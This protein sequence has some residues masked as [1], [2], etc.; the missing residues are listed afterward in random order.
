LVGFR[1][2][3]AIPAIVIAIGLLVAGAVAAIAAWLA[4][5]FTARVPV[6][7]YNFLGYVTAYLLRLNAYIAL[8]TDTWP[9][10]ASA[11]PYPVAIRF[12]GPERLNRAA[13]IF[14]VVL[15][16]PAYVVSGVASGGLTVLLPVFWLIIL[17]AGRSPEPIFDATTASV[18]YQTRFAAYFF[19]LTSAYP[20][21][22]FVKTTADA[23]PP[24]VPA[25]PELEV[26]R[27]GDGGRRL[28]ILL[29][30]L[31]VVGQGLQLAFRSLPPLISAVRDIAAETRLSDAYADVHLEA[32]SSCPPGAGQLQCL[33]SYDAAKL[34]Q[35][36]RFDSRV[37]DI[38]FPRHASGDVAFLRLAT[39][40]LIANYQRLTE[41]T[42]LA[43]YDRAEASLPGAIAT[44]QEGERALDAELLG[45]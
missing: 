13:V 41:A 42:T 19:L 25:R 9:T 31:G 22:L 15:A 12:P 10:L 38:S 16:V 5:V 23:A 44:F 37:A 26:P 4:A 27:L 21:D 2:L 40:A 32:N 33:Q 30:V 36:R 39:G 35:L 11:E 20:K 6:G 24:P 14:R 45:D 3:L 1:L 28:L 8:L 18:R 17:I 7:L 29:L 34:I 43:A